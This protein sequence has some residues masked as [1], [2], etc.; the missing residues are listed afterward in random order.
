MIIFYQPNNIYTEI[1][2]I[3]KEISGNNQIVPFCC[4]Y[5]FDNVIK[6]CVPDY[7]FQDIREGIC[8][9]CVREFLQ[10]PS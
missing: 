2:H 4:D 6:E 3:A 1:V 7:K 5:S 9:Y 8:V 10:T